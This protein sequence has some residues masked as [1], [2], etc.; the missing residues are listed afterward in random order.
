MEPAW[1]PEFLLR[2]YE[3]FL[4]YLGILL[5][6][7]AGVSFLTYLAFLFET[8]FCRRVSLRPY[9]FTRHLPARQSLGGHSLDLSRVER[10]L[11]TF[12]DA[13]HHSS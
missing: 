8:C 2:T 11:A 6:V 7:I 1:S 13:F 12:L 4:L 10:S 9:S 5:G 3:A